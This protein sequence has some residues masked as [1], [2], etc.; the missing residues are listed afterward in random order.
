MLSKALLIG[1]DAID[2]YNATQ[3]KG[4]ISISSLNS[5]M[6]IIFPLLLPVVRITNDLRRN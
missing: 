1:G 6:K 2:D 5:Y 4:V 3:S